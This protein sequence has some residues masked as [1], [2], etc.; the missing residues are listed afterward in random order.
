MILDK[1]FD[2]KHCCRFKNSINIDIRQLC[3]QVEI[4]T[5]MYSNYFVIVTGRPKDR[6]IENFDQ[7]GFK[8]R[9]MTFGCLKGIEKFTSTPDSSILLACA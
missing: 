9:E 4:I 7:N 2:F 8:R 1:T 6:T 3:L 5:Y